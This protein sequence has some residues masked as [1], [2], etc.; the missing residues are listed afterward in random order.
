MGF[1]EDFAC[2]ITQAEIQGSLILED[3]QEEGIVHPAILPGRN[4]LLLQRPLLVIASSRSSQHRECTKGTTRGPKVL[5]KAKPEGPTGRGVTGFQNGL[6]W[7]G[8]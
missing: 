4:S 1:S 5:G 6:P 7:K 3:E 8:C 2:C